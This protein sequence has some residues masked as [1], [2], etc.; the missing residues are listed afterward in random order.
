[1][2]LSA[3]VF[4]KGEKK[5]T[6]NTA[7]CFSHAFRFETLNQAENYALKTCKWVYIEVDAVRF[8]FNQLHS[9]LI[10]DRADIR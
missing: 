8:Q 9:V 5:S 3:N 7:I 1:M 4:L 6:Y 10:L 2:K